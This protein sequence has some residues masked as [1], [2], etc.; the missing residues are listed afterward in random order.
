MKLT[1]RQ[2]ELLRGLRTDVPAPRENYG[3]RDQRLL[4]GLVARG[5]AE[6]VPS[7][8]ATSTKPA[9]YT[10][11]EAAEDLQ[12]ELVVD[13]VQGTRT[14]S[15]RHSA[16]H[17]ESVEYIEDESSTQAEHDAAHHLRVLER[18]GLG[19]GLRESEYQPTVQQIAEIA[20]LLE[21]FEEEAQ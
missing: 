16:E 18:W 12:A 14:R 7:A 21:L 9:G 8:V 19:L 17:V 20:A 13:Q 1:Y 2:A 11:A 3:I 6:Y 15:R 10:L 5:Y 4:D